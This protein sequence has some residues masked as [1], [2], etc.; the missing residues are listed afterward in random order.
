MD[1]TTPSGFGPSIC[2]YNG[3]TTITINAASANEM[4]RLLIES[5]L[6][7]QRPLHVPVE[8]ADVYGRTYF[9]RAVWICFAFS[10]CAANAGAALTI[11]SLS[12]AFFEFGINILFTNSMTAW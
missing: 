8:P 3:E 10:T 9:P 6:H 1:E 7:A 2:A 11:S 5:S 12:S 4:A